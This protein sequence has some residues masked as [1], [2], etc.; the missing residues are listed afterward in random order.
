[1]G[2]TRPPRSR[3]PP[4]TRPAIDAD[5]RPQD[6]RAGEPVRHARRGCAAPADRPR[7]PS[8]SRWRGS[9][10]VDHGSVAIAAITSCTN[11]SNPSVMVA[12][13][14]LARNAV[15]RGLRSQPWVKTSLSPGVEG[16]DR[17]PRRRRA[18]PVPGGARLPPRRLR[19]HD[20]HRRLR[21][22]HPRDRRGGARARPQRRVRALGQPELRRADQSRRPDELPRLAAA[23]RRLRP[24][25]HHGHRPHHRAPRQ[26]RATGAR[27]T[28]ATSGPTPTRSRPSSTRP[29]T[30]RCSPGPTPTSS[31]ATS[32]GSRLDAPAGATFAWDEDSTYLR[33]PPYL[34]G[35]T[36]EPSP[37]ADID[38]AGCWSSSATPSPPTTSPRPGRSRVHTPAG[39]YLTGLGV[40]RFQL[41]TY[42]SRRGNHEVMMRGC[43][44]NVRLRNQLV[45]GVEGGWTLNLL[46][47]RGVERVRRRHG[48][49]RRRRPAGGRRRART[50][51]AGPRGTGRPRAR[52]CWGSAPCWPSPSSGS[53]G[54]T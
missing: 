13:G 31:T 20:L 41:N 40:E 44:A 19:L 9:T 24:R 6:A 15:D 39:Q 45:P 10:T 37:V 51:A 26:R 23:G 50:T 11:T 52:P 12:A 27:S 32:A 54:R 43:F 49:P 48:L 53:T 4:A 14:L 8:R 30:P 3:S 21:P 28:C 7:R 1:M 38:G 42:A 16:G 47:R 2:R 18:D 29:S 25:R 22:A 5:D 33:R 35:M 36:R 34:D 17:L 46:C